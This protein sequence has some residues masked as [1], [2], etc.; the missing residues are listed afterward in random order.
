MLL[1]QYDAG[2]IVYSE[3]NTNAI[4]KNYKIVDFDKDNFW[5]SS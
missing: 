1:A 5:I 3:T 2:T 4:Q